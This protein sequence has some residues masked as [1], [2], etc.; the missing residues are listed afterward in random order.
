MNIFVNFGQDKRRLC[1]WFGL[2]QP[3]DPEYRIVTS[4]SLQPRILLGVRA[5][6]AT[7]CVV[8]CILDAVYQTKS[9]NPSWW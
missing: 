9:G 2:N 1:S 8:T 6:F 7:F 5:S 4:G 3:F